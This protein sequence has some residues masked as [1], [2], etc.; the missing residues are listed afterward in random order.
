V[1]SRGNL[2]LPVRDTAGGGRAADADPALHAAPPVPPDRVRAHGAG[3]FSRGALFGGPGVTRVTVLAFVVAMTWY[4]ALDYIVVGFREL[5]R[6]DPFRA[7]HAC[8]WSP[9]SRCRSS[10]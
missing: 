7:L 9:D 10:R 6:P 1:A 8:A 4:S 5:L 2:T 3:W